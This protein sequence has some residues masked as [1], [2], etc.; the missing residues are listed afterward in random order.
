MTLAAKI[1]QEIEIPEGVTIQ[2]ETNKVTVVGPKGQIT[3]EYKIG[4]IKIEQADNK[5]KISASFPK[6]QQKAMIGTIKGKIENMINGVNHGYEYKM[7]IVYSHFPMN[8]NVENQNIKI[9]NFLG[10]K[11]PR[12]S[13][14][15]GNTQVKIKGQDITITGTNKE[16]VGQTAGN[17]VLAT[18][19][20]RRDQR[21]FKDG[22]FIVEKNVMKND[23]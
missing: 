13:K 2:I 14:I 6:K 5:I 23:A 7:Q 9:K 4:P 20:G 18:K 19:V 8:V 16:E 1:E 12:T 22:I 21:V 15:L 3:E 11:H 17:L 10:E